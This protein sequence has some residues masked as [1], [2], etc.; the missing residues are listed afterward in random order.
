MKVKTTKKQVRE[1]YDV[2]IDA[3]NGNAQTLLKPLDAKWYVVDSIG[4]ACDV[5]E[6]GWGVVLTDGRQS[7]GTVKPD[8]ELMRRYEEKAK[9]IVDSYRGKIGEGA[10][11][12]R[13]MEIAELRGKFVDEV[14]GGGKSCVE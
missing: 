2:I 4:W 14:L 6:V 9:E 12:K 13:N 1:S 5:Y 7:F 11:T 8:R 10:H 3:G